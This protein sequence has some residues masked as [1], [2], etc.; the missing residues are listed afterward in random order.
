MSLADGGF[1]HAGQAG[2]LLVAAG[3]AALV[4]VIGFL[5]PCV[6]PLVPGYLS[7]ISAVPFSA[8]NLLEIVFWYGISRMS[9][10]GSQT[11]VGPEGFRISTRVVTSEV[12]PE[13]VFASA[14]NRR[15]AF[16]ARRLADP[17]PAA[18]RRG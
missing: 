8:S 6:L 4:G 7:T 11:R 1:T 5:S 14:P 15:S 13:S 10:A 12:R 17:R 18:R 9:A 16:G 3:V 2:P